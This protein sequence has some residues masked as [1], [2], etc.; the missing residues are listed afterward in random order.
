MIDPVQTRLN[1]PLHFPGGTKRYVVARVSALE[2]GHGITFAEEIMQEIV[3]LPGYSAAETVM[4]NV[5][6]SAYEWRFFESPVDR[7]V[8]F[9]RL[10]SPLTG[11]NRSYVGPDKRQF[12]VQV[13]SFFSPLE[14]K[15]PNSLIAFGLNNRT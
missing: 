6:G 2:P 3:P 12:F 10:S 4:E 8:S 5:I 1:R 11:G 9:D 7:S 14:W 15:L 13:G